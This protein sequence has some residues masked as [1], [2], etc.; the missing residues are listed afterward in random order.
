[1]YGTMVKDGA[2]WFTSITS[3]GERDEDV[4]HC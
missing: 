1:M 3:A 2:L 4:G